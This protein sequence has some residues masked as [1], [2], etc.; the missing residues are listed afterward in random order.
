MKNYDKAI[1]YKLKVV[2]TQWLEEFYINLAK[3]KV[4]Q[5]LNRCLDNNIC[6]D[7]SKF[8]VKIK[9]SDRIALWENEVQSAKI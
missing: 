4:F 5:I 9:E 2:N 6:A 1:E 7:F 3:N 8:E